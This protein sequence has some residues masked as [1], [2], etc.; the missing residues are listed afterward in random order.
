[1]CT[2]ILM[3]VPQLEPSASITIDMFDIKL[4]DPTLLVY[5]QAIYK[6]V[7]N[8]IGA[9][10]S[11]ELCQP[12]MIELRKY[13]P[14]FTPAKSDTIVYASVEE[15]HSA[16][17]D[18]IS[19]YLKKLK[20]DIKVGDPNFPSCVILCGDQQTYSIVVQLKMS[21]PNMYN[22]FYPFP[23]DWHTMKLCS[24]VIRDMLWDGGL[25]QFCN[26]CF[27]KGEL[28][29]WQDIHI[30]L[31]SVYET[32]LEI[33]I[34][35]FNSTC[36]S[37]KSNYWE[38]VQ[39]ITDESNKDEISRFWS[40]VLVILHF[41]TGFYFSIRSGNWHMRNVFLKALAPLFLLTREASMRN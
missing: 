14:H 13:M 16:N 18:D 32:L 21:Q 22:W 24:E 33:S 7:H 2:K 38:W 10:G 35:E 41:Y 3:P 25:K 31:L 27:L 9:F 20:L 15:G 28:H 34:E 8:R 11:S 26:A 36:D 6:I 1:M 5:N 12:V 39:S 19:Q 40:Q 23:G 4:V 17:K 30:M 29:Q 37:T